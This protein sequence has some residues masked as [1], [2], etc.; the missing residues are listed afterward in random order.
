VAVLDQNPNLIMTYAQTNVID[1]DGSIQETLGRT[2][3]EFTRILPHIMK[4]MIWT[5]SSCLWRRSQAGDPSVW[6]PLYAAEDTL[7]DF[8]IGL[9]DQPIARTPTDDPL[10]GKRVHSENLSCNLAEDAAY[11]QEILKAY[12]LMWAALEQSDRCAD[13]RRQMARLYASKI[14]TFLVLRRYWEAQHCIDR[15]RDIDRQALP[16]DARIAAAINRVSGT[17]AGFALLRRWRWAGKI[18]R[19][20]ISRSG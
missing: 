12:D 14:M 10:I 3:Q 13:Y 2:D 16:L 7:H 4:R 17:Q 18:A 19:R 8:L 15:A 6:Q 20:R 11:Q 1:A 9:R 5:T